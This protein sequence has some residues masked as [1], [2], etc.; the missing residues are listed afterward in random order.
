MRFVI[1]AIVLAF[2][3]AD[4]YLTARIARWTGVPLWLWLAGSFVA[5][6]LLLHHERNEFRMKTVA[7][8][9]GG[10]PVLRGLLDSGRRV[11]AGFLLIL[12]GIASDI[13][14]LLLLALPLNLGGSVRPIPAAAGVS[15]GR[16]E[17]DA[18][19]GDYRRIE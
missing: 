6:A 17:F 4:L 19:D 15:Q 14:A 18:I 16:G 2:P 8:L 1:L 3:L 11:L 7:A 10:Q 12:P 5:G 13:I 9:H